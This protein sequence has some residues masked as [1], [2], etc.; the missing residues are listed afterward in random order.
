[1]IWR[2]SS[3]SFY[4]VYVLDYYVSKTKSMQVQLGDRGAVALTFL[5]LQHHFQQFHSIFVVDLYLEMYSWQ[6]RCHCIAMTA[7]IHIPGEFT[8]MSLVNS[9]YRKRSF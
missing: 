4:G 1:M 6:L 2:I 8:P 3:S 7:Q 9:P 5:T